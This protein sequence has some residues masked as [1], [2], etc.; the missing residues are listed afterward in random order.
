[1]PRADTAIVSTVECGRVR[2]AVNTATRGLVTRNP[3]NAATPEDQDPS[4]T[5]PS[6]PTLNPFLEPVK[7]Q[8]TSASSTVYSD[9]HLN[10]GIA[11]L[12]TFTNAGG[13][14]TL[15]D[16]GVTLNRIPILLTGSV[17]TT[18]LA[19]TVDWL[20]G[21][22]CL[23]CLAGL[24][25]RVLRPRKAPTAPARP[26]P[27]ARYPRPRRAHRPRRGWQCR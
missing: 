10:V 24:A 3:P 1:M 27:H 13:L 26:R 5:V 21:L 19:L 9:S 20:A 25:E 11:T 18:V 6:P 8:S 7:K 22:A 16:T 12:A 23:A 4:P 17:L 2:N 15:I 14:G